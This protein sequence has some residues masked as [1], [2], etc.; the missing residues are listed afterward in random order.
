LEATLIPFTLGLKDEL[1]LPPIASICLG[2]MA[3]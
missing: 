1:L 3:L 2:Q